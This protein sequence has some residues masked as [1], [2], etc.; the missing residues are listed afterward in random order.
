MPRL[1][2]MVNSGVNAG[3]TIIETD[4]FTVSEGQTTFIL[5]S[6]VEKPQNLMVFVDGI[7]TNLSA[8]SVTTNALT[9]LSSLA[10]NAIVKVVH[11]KEVTVVDRSTTPLVETFVGG[12]VNYVLYQAPG[13]ESSILVS[14]NGNIQPINSYSVSGTTLTFN[15]ITPVGAVIIVIHLVG[16]IIA[17]S[18][19]LPNSI[20]LDHL[21]LDSVDSR[22]AQ[23][24]NTYTKSE[25]DYK[26][27]SV[28][29]GAPELLDTLSELAAALNN[30]P[31][32][33]TNVYQQLVA[34]SPIVHDHNNIY[35]NKT[36]LNAFLA[37]KA[38]IDT[39]Y[40]QGQ[41]D[42]L[43]GEKADINTTYTKVEVD[44]LISTGGI[45]IIPISPGNR[46]IFAGGNGLLG[47]DS[48]IE[49]FTLNTFGNSVSFGT[50]SS[51]I[52][53]AAGSSNGVNNTGLISGGFTTSS[54]SNISKINILSN[55]NATDFG[56]LLSPR[57]EHCALSNGTNNRSVFIGGSGGF[58]S[59]MEYVTTN[60]PSHSLVFGNLLG[61]QKN[62]TSGT[63]NGTHDRGVIGILLSSNSFVSEFITIPVLS[64]AVL[65]G[66]LYSGTQVAAASNDI[67]DRGVFA[68]G[69][70]S[71]VNTNVIEYINIAI[72]GNSVGFGTLTIA[73]RSLSGTSNGKNQRAIFAGGIDANMASSETD[74]ITISTASNA[75]PFGDLMIKKSGVASFSNGAL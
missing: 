33:A 20:T 73:R 55:S 32:F 36:E 25:I 70:V 41:I 13:T 34:K 47:N 62:G 31:N 9:F 19:T 60:T 22:Y 75:A 29:A 16:A 28:I 63:S 56:L 14:V 27:D 11:F 2:D 71:S 8:Y 18:T 52:K 21:A 69:L 67:N 4:Y 35:Y 30:D 39:H 12:Q 51:A 58:T 48:T 43:L 1:S 45:G 7:Q 5:K 65:F 6:A 15:S 50:L 54:I 38:S 59:D 42:T 49:Y 3:N 37:S 64:N 74:F 57:S 66:Q 68:G 10:A 44:N 53:F 23:I 17:T 46:G 40:N 26:I 61:T 24:T 72:Q